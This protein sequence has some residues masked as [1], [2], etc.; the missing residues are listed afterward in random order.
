MLS[1]NDAFHT[2][3]KS[4]K[5]TTSLLQQSSHRH[6]TRSDLKICPNELINSM[7]VSAN[8]MVSVKLNAGE[9]PSPMNRNMMN[10]ANEHILDPSLA[11]SKGDFIYPTTFAF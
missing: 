4:L 10:D 8:E 7:P 2:D 9:R 1:N 11:I 6:H 3:A 5:A